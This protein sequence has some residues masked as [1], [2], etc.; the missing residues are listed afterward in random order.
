M[1]PR[2]AVH[3]YGYNLC[4]QGGQYIRMDIICATKEG[5]T[6]V[7]CTC[8]VM[9]AT[10]GGAIVHMCPLLYLLG[11]THTYMHINYMYIENIAGM[12][13]ALYRF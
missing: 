10:E 2:R 12:C 1:S 13:V 5:S 8:N 11:G 7:L 9:C 3:T 6:Y 4:H